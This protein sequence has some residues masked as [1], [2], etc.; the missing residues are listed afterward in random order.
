[1]FLDEHPDSI[2]DGY[3]LE[4]DY[5][6]EWHDLPASYHNGSAA[7]S[8][9][10]GHSTLHRWLVPTTVTPSAPNAA[11]LPIPVPASLSAD[12]EWVTD[13]MSIES[14]QHP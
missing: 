8:Y 10:G 2:N 1:M 7:F 12:F 3:F 6:L 14:K 9:A 4:R 13:N 11:N 5:Y